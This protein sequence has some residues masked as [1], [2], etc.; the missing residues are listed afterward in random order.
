MNN[1]SRD[2]MFC[3]T[4]KYYTSNVYKLDV[5]GFETLNKIILNGGNITFSFPPK[6]GVYKVYLFIIRSEFQTIL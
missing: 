1:G 2:L 4:P 3:F 5:Q 6:Y